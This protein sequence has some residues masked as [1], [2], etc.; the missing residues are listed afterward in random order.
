VWHLWARRILVG[1]HRGQI[2]LGKPRHTLEGNINK[3]LKE[4]RWECADWLR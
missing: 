1:K 2:P 3:G 4:I